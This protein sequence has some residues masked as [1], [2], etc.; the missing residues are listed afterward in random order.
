M[1]QYTSI[2]KETQIEL[3]I[4]KS[5]FIGFLFPVKDEIDAEEKLEEIREIHKDATHNCFAYRIGINGQVQKCSDDGE[6]QGTAGLPM[7]EI[8]NKEDITNVLA[9]A[10][11]YYGGVKLGAGGLIR[12]YAQTVKEALDASE[13]V[14]AKMHWQAKL[15]IDYKDLEPIK[16]ILLNEQ[17][18]IEEIEYLERVS[19]TMLIPLELKDEI[20][21]KIL[22]I[23]RGQDEISIIKKKFAK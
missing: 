12:A 1:E 22:D 3:I 14:T 4:K 11:R 17:I 19:L 10:T 8:L 6:P 16:N 7:L 18:T 23:T 13:I 2:K 15:N 5:K 20:N 21:N 9:I